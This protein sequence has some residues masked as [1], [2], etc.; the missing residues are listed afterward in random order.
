MTG[1]FNRAKHASNLKTRIIDN[2][3]FQAL[4]PGSLL[5]PESVS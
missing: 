4:G 2:S 3:R 5:R 1:R